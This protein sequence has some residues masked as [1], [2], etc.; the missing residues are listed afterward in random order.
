MLRAR[1]LAA[2]AGEERAAHAVAMTRW[3]VHSQMDRVE[4]RARTALAGA[5]EGD[6]LRN[7]GTILQR[8]TRRDSVD[9]IS[10]R[11]QIA[12]R[13]IEQGKYVV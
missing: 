2:K 7:L 8:L 4:S 9:T 5:A 11:R 13:V 1:K 12:A 10:L 3:W 6:A